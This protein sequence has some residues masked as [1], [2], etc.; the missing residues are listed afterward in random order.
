MLLTL[1]FVKT[2]FRHE[3]NLTSFKDVFPSLLGHISSGSAAG[4]SLIKEKKKK[5]LRLKMVS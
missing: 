5:A 2:I 4:N 3:S 1:V